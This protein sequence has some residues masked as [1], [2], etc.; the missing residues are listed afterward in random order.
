MKIW[1]ENNTT[2]SK[3]GPTSRDNILPQDLSQSFELSELPIDITDL[4]NRRS[5]TE[6]SPKRKHMTLPTEI[7]PE[8]GYDPI[9]IFNKHKP[10]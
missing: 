9:K 7:E 6:N 10:I 3:V 8:N 2:K 1:A 5:G 4:K